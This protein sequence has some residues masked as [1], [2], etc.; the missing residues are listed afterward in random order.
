MNKRYCG[1]R[2]IPD[3]PVSHVC[4]KPRE[5]V[6]EEPL[7]CANC[8]HLE[9]EAYSLSLEE[10]ITALGKLVIELQREFD[11]VDSACEFWKETAIEL[12]Y[13]E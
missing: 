3:G 11:I 8:R 9:L 10:D 2:C 7:Q 4:G 12:G 5:G 13:E 6:A 1:Y